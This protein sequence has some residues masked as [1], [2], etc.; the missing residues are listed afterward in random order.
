M[1]YH[2]ITFG[3]QMN[4]SDSERIAGLLEKNNYSPAINANEADL[5]VV[6]MCSIR[7]TAVDR[8]FGQIN[9]F[10]KLKQQNPK[11]KIILTGCV[12]ESDFKKIQSKKEYN[13]ILPVKTLSS[14]GKLLRQKQ[15][16]NLPVKE[17]NTSI[18][19]LKI[20]PRY[21]SKFSAFV[22]IVVGC[23]NFCSY[24][25]VPY[26]R[27][28][29]I[30][31]PL[32]DI[33]KEVKNLVKAGYKE[34][35]LI[36]E[37]VNSYKHRQTNFSKLLKTIDKIPGN[38]W[39][40]FTSSHPKDFSDELIDTIAQGNKLTKYISL[41]VQSGD[42]KILKRMNRPYTIK[43]YKDL[44][45]K[46][47]SKIPDAML[48]T[49][50]IVGFPGET[51]KQFRNTIKLFKEIKPDMAYVAQY[52]A[53][54]GTKAFEME[55]NISKREKINRDKA[56]TEI[57]RQ[58]ALSNNKKCIGRE[59][60]ILV[61]Y[62]RKGW[63]VGKTR[64]YRTIKIPNPKLQIPNKSKIQNSKKL[65]NP[66]KIKNLKKTQTQDLIGKIVKVKVID[67]IPWGLKGRLAE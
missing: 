67:A 60:E 20:L 11:L 22:P 24:C 32:P 16:V 33:V 38:F 63:L 57:L 4:I 29:E 53:R 65:K 39:L 34:I 59:V 58:T 15:Y 30:S 9:N 64:E 62:G 12:L 3:C 37:N 35:W 28:P 6:V 27:G 13:Y 14:W 66:N 2:I 25:V 21:N 40:R 50:V 47:K 5:I 26:T 42:D 43:Q 51:K 48:S 44:I 7:Q 23:N 10:K 19:Y 61:E 49:D 45:K 31:R 41:P 56:I 52:S 17:H 36:G 18:D 8:V 46:I 54:K 1:K 55:D